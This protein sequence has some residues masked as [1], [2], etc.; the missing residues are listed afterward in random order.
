LQIELFAFFQ[1]TIAFLLPDVLDLVSSVIDQ[2]G[3]ELSR[4]GIKCWLRLLGVSGTSSK[5]PFI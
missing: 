2:E 1:D 4:I 3:E 5:A